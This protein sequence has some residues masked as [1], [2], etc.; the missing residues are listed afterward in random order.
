ME[1]ATSAAAAAAVDV[2][3]DAAVGIKEAPGSKDLN[4]AWRR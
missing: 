1:K 2:E 3:V 4:A